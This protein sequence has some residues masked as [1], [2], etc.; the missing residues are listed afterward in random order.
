ML[1]AQIPAILLV[2]TFIRKVTDF[3]A[4][5]VFSSG[6]FVFLTSHFLPI[7]S[8]INRYCCLELKFEKII[9]PVIIFCEVMGV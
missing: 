1:L 3:R 6:N 5:V 7:F 9:L 4:R 2:P 8:S